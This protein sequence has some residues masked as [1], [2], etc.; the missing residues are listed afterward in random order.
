MQG[1]VLLPRLEC[2]GAIIAHYN[3]E[4]LRSTEPPTSASKVAGTTEMGSCYIVQ[5]SL[6]LL[7]S[8]DPPASASQSAGDYRSIVHNRAEYSWYVKKRVGA[9]FEEALWL[10]TVAYDCNPSILD[11]LQWCDLGSLQPLP[12]GFKRFSCLSLRVAEITGARHHTWLIFVF[13]VETGFWLVGQAGLE[14]LTSGDPP[15]S[16]SQ[17]ARIT[18]RSCGHTA[19][20]SLDRSMP[21]CQLIPEQQ[22]LE[23]PPF[24][25]SL[26]CL[27]WELWQL[28]KGDWGSVVQSQLT[29]ASKS[30]AHLGLQT[31]GQLIFTF[32]VEMGSHFLAQ[33]GL[34]LPDSSNPPA[35]AS[36]SAGMT[37]GPHFQ[38]EIGK[39]EW[40]TSGTISIV[41]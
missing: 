8:R 17:N 23:C 40:V 32:F 35:L 16:A 18:G 21:E 7:G 3:L 39:A 27:S 29:A 6:E 2:S 34:K 13:L 11:G 26:S 28:L 41:I 25:N 20:Q 37:C 9:A 14:L 4:L 36:Q 22:N 31:C 12:P 1:L 10:A 15:A 5:A 19:I 38:K 24:W 33:A 30:W